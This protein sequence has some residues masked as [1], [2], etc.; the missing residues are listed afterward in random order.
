MTD[1]ELDEFF[2]SLASV[3]RDLDLNAFQHWQKLKEVVA[4]TNPSLDKW[5]LS[6]EE[7]SVFILW[8]I[9]GEDSEDGSFAAMPS[10]E[11]AST[12]EMAASLED[13]KQTCIDDAMV[14][15][16]EFD[17]GSMFDLIMEA[18]RIIDA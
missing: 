17:Y 3:D 10:L 12:D 8:R 11:L 2:D 5:G 14:T 16:K 1:D 4:S 9:F 6:L 7:F 13:F 15:D 18:N